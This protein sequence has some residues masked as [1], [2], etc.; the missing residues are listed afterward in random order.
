VFEAHG[1]FYHSILGLRVIK[2]RREEPCSDNQFP[3][4]AQVSY[5][6]NPRTLSLETLTPEP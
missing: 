6:L 3:D 5:P 1:P 4:I 2:K